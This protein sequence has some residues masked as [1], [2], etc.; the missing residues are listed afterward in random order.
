MTDDKREGESRLQCES[1]PIHRNTALEESLIECRQRGEKA[2][3]QNEGDIVVSKS[4]SPTCLM[5]AI[6]KGDFKSAAALLNGGSQVKATEENSWTALH[7]SAKQGR[8]DLTRLLLEHGFNINAKEGSAGKTPLHLVVE[9]GS[10]CGKNSFLEV[11]KMILKCP[12][13]DPNMKDVHGDTPLH[14]AMRERNTKFLR[15]LIFFG[16]RID[17]PNSSGEAVLPYLIRK[18]PKLASEAFDRCLILN[19]LSS[20]DPYLRLI[21]NY[22]I[23]DILNSAGTKN[24]KDCCRRESVIPKLIVNSRNHSLLTHPLC[25]S[26]L[27]LKWH[28]FRRFYYINSFLFFLFAVSLTSF[29]MTSVNAFR[30]SA[31]ETSAIYGDVLQLDYADKALWYGLLLFT[32]YIA[33]REFYQF[34]SKPSDYCRDPENIFEL[35]V[36]IGV[37]MILFRDMLPVGMLIH[38]SA[39]VVLAVWVEVMLLLGRHPTC[40]VYV[41]MLVDVSKNVFRILAIFLILLFA[42]SLSFSIL[43][44]EDRDFDSWYQALAKTTVMMTGEFDYSNLPFSSY[45]VT[46]HIVFLGFVL[47]ATIVLMNLLVGLA[48]N[49]IKRIN[50]KAIT[51]SIFRQVVLMAYIEKMLFSPVINWFPDFIASRWKSMAE[52]TLVLKHLPNLTLCTFPNSKTSGSLRVLRSRESKIDQEVLEKGMGKD[53]NE[54]CSDPECQCWVS[55]RRHVSAEA[56]QDAVD[57]AFKVRTSK[58]SEEKSTTNWNNAEEVAQTIASIRDE[59]VS[60]KMDIADIKNLLRVRSNSTV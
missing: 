20:E 54:H 60:L 56:I 36:V 38:A 26:F 6:A 52:S 58:M 14:Y 49:D 53:E 55:M 16:A 25:L 40:S 5:D 2:S 15:L 17:V 9:Q 47:A 29:V 18:H 34:L 11:A 27:Q 48:V 24:E 22:Q 23:F 39:L 50:E 57:V 7:E 43:F 12:G 35:I 30:Q 8:V 21:F 3:S 1:L 4:V 32:A 45:P 33:F 51:Y 37:L 19:S 44:M 10:R 41:S 42:F 28:Y 31:N 13:V 46:S 59:I